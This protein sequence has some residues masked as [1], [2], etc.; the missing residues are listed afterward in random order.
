MDLTYGFLITSVILRVAF[1][2]TTS[3]MGE[4][5]LG[6]SGGIGFIGICLFAFVAFQAM[7]PSARA[8]YAKRAAAFGQIKF[9]S[10]RPKPMSRPLN[11]K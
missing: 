4:R 5:A 1:G 10:S 2:F 7:T 11:L 3:E 8:A 9:E 6:A